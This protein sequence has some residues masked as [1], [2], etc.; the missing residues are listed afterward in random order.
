MTAAL[1]IK[2]IYLERFLSRRSQKKKNLSRVDIPSQIVPSPFGIR[3]NQMSKEQY[4]PMK[5]TFSE[6]NQISLKNILE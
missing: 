5:N 2:S 6:S 1:S 4:N 3:G